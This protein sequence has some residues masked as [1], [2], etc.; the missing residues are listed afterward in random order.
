[1]FAFALLGSVGFASVSI[2]DVTMARA[3][4]VTPAVVSAQGALADAMGARD[5]ECRSGAGRF[6]RER[7]SAV[8]DARHALDLAVGTVTGTAD[9]QSAAAI[10]MVGWVTGGA[11]RPTEDDFAMVRLALL[12]LLPQLGGVLLMIGRAK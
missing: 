7:E 9:P 5:R 12:C 6:C 8:V 4:R 10:R 11:I 1:V 2:S 3:S